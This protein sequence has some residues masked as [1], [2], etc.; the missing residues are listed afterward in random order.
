MAF[1]LFE[2]T[3]YLVSLKR[4]GTRGECASIDCFGEGLPEKRINI[5]F[6]PK[7]AMLPYNRSS[8]GQSGAVLGEMYLPAER[9]AWYLD[10]LRNEAP[11]QARVDTDNP[12][13]NCIMTK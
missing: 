8:I 7:D 3:H 4:I 9:Y 2:V 12:D 11:I 13:R 1:M 10:L 5:Y 6:M